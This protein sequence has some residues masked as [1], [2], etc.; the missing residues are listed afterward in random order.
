MRHS[1]LFWRKIT[2][3]LNS[4]KFL[5][6]TLTIIS[7]ILIPTILIYSAFRQYNIDEL[8]AFHSAWKIFQGKQIFVDFF[9][10]HHPLIYYLLAP[11][12][13]IFGTNTINLL[14]ARFFILIIL[15]IL[16]LSTYKIAKTFFD[17]TTAWITL[18]FMLTNTGFLCSAI[19]IRP[20]IGQVCTG[21]ISLHLLFL[22]LYKKHSSKKHLYLYSSAFF[23]GIS[24]LFLQKAYPI[25]ILTGL[26]LLH[27]FF[28]KRIPFKTLIIYPAMFNVPVLFYTLFLYFTNALPQYFE[29]NW[30]LN[31]KINASGGPMGAS[32]YKTLLYFMPRNP[33]FWFLFFV[34]IFLAKKTHIQK[35]VVYFAIGQFIFMFTFKSHGSQYLM[36]VIPFASILAANTCY[37]IKKYKSTIFHDCFTYRL[38]TPT[39][40]HHLPWWIKSICRTTYLHKIFF[41]HRK[42][43]ASCIIIV[44]TLPGIATYWRGAYLTSKTEQIKKIDY[45]LSITDKDDYILGGGNSVNLYRNTVDFFWFTLRSKP[46]IIKKRI[47][48]KKPKI[49]VS[50]ERLHNDVLSSLTGYK[51]DKNYPDI[52][53]KDNLPHT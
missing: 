16:S 43:L 26:L 23:M 1:T 30:L 22:Y 15:S 5:R 6:S 29:Y 21:V 7:I 41:N 11:I 53:I 25:I 13:G 50:D 45:L 35:K 20:D 44:T 8:E 12:I 17:K 36:P 18:L 34:G 9:Q 38:H 33:F 48:E 52:L 40:R 31:F 14:F 4:N 10:H 32:I 27:Q 39:K 42:I 49:I 46:E 28:R 51:P 3:F 24:F 2:F 47:Q 37:A 19:E